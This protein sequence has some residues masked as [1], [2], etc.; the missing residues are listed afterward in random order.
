VITVIII[1]TFIVVV[2]FGAGN[3]AV[4]DG[5][6]DGISTWR[7]NGVRVAAERVPKVMEEGESEKS[8]H[9]LKKGGDGLL[10]NAGGR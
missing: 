4:G 10:N 7:L 2:V 9:M 8:K 3:V 6:N 1:I 5:I